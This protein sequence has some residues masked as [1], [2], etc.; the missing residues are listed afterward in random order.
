MQNQESLFLLSAFD[1]CPSQ[2]CL[3][4]QG[5]ACEA[6]WKAQRPLLLLGIFILISRTK[7]ATYQLEYLLNGKNVKLNFP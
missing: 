6:C 2:V 4:F 5:V 3:S 7:K 1:E